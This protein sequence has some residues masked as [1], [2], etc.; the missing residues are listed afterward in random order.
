MKVS[1]KPN[2]FTLI[3]TVQELNEK[4]PLTSH[5]NIVIWPC[6]LRPLRLVLTGSRTHWTVIFEMKRKNNTANVRSFIEESSQF[7]IIHHA[8]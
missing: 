3:L 2:Y 1:L 4:G 8:Q 7:Q 5:R 6:L